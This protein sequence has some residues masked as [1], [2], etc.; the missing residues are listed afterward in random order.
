MSS[1]LLPSAASSRAITAWK[2]ANK[3]HECTQQMLQRLVR[4]LEGE[5]RG[6]KGEVTCSSKRATQRF[7]SLVLTLIQ[8]LLLLLLQL[9]LQ[10][11]LLLVLLFAVA[12][13]DVLVAAA[14]VVVL[15]AAAAAAAVAVAAAEIDVQRKAALP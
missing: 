4:Y 3:T 14:S 10:L 5:R 15:F 12:A 7:F 2:A 1:E 6:F 8:L 9:L 11:L 13:V